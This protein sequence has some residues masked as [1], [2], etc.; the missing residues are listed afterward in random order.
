MSSARALLC[1]SRRLG[2]RL[3]ERALEKSHRS[4]SW[5]DRVGCKPLAIQAHTDRQRSPALISSAAQ[6]RS[7]GFR[8][9]SGRALLALSAAAIVLAA[10]GSTH[11]AH[12]PRPPVRT[13][14]SAGPLV[15]AQPQ[16]GR[17][18]IDAT[19]AAARAIYRNETEG[20]KLPRELRRIARDGTLL[21]ALSR[22]DLAGA[23]AEAHRQLRIR[24]NHTA[25]V[26]RISVIRGP[27]VLVNATVNSDGVFVVTP[28][29]R[30]LRFHGRTLGM[31]LVSLQDVTGYVKLITDVTH[32][33]ALV[34]GASGHVR[35]SLP[36]A[37]RVRLPARGEVTIA[38][39]SY[40]TRSFREKAWGNE[41]L[42]V[43]I[44]QRT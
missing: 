2:R 35:T 16:A 8:S 23:Q 43:W 20:A 3:G 41:P 42:T 39:R 44:F 17:N 36:A 32:A 31:L 33:D 34:R 15:I 1:R 4:F 37:R 29:R 10:C 27:R 40:L 21:R 13:F 38:G 22:G 6:T 5:G 24:L 12:T 25:H 18:R 19:V 9:G 7:A 26:T 30:L 28:G 14:A 11:P